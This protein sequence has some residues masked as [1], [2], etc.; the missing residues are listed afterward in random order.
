SRFFQCF[1]NEV[2]LLS[3]LSHENIIKFIGFVE[4]TEMGV[5][6]IVIPWEDNGNLREFVKLQ[7]W[8]IPERL[9]L[10]CDVARGVEYLHTSNP[11]ICHGDL[12]SLNILVNSEHRAVITDFGS[13]RKL[14]PNQRREK[15]SGTYITLTGPVFTLR[16]AA[17]ELLAEDEFS[18]ASDI[19]AF[20]WICWEI[21][22]G[23]IPF[24]ELARDAAIVRRVTR[25]DL[26]VI[27]NNEQISQ[28]RA[29]CKMMTR[30]WEM[31]PEERPAAKECKDLLNWMV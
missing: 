22:T 28:V 31:N 23:S 16:W 15:A 30:C 24:D 6:W 17:P 3:G 18:L 29:L 27:A 25:G 4:N 1:A 21:M 14:D 19:W 9:S 2:E 7:D 10:I 5:A 20:G 26:P 13:A 8:V 11:P 12:K